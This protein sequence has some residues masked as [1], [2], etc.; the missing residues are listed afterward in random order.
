M[1]GPESECLFGVCAPKAL[2][3]FTPGPA[4][5][6]A[7]GEFKILRIWEDRA[8]HTPSP[9]PWVSSPLFT[10]YGKGAWASAQKQVETN[11]YATSSGCSTIKGKR[12]VVVGEVGINQGSRGTASSSHPPPYLGGGQR[13]R[14]GGKGQGRGWGEIDG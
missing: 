6:W 11:S 3:T 9:L 14:R 2:C 7:P 10:G 13:L 4:L 8:Q 12:N 1:H 5:R